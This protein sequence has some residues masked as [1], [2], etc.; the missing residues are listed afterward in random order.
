MNEVVF[1]QVKGSPSDALVASAKVRAKQMHLCLRAIGF[2][3][4][5]RREKISLSPI[6]VAPVQIYHM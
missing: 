5:C 3:H 6:A 2:Q 1:H 4:G